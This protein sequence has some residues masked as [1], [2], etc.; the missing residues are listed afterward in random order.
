MATACLI[1]VTTSQ[2]KHSPLHSCYQNLNLFYGSSSTYDF[3]RRVARTRAHTR[4]CL[5]GATIARSAPAWHDT[6]AATI[7][8]PATQHGDACCL[9]RARPTAAW[10]RRIAAALAP[11]TFHGITASR[12]TPRDVY[13]IRS[14]TVCDANVFSTRGVRC[15][16]E[17]RQTFSE[18]RTPRDTAY[19]ASGD[20]KHTVC[21]PANRWMLLVNRVAKLST[22]GRWALV[23]PLAARATSAYHR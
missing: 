5:F 11:Q 14:L 7:H 8:M 16:S 19:A 4:T 3:S 20:L 22:A 12:R 17:R 6:R 15:L 1:Y 9:P 10:R 13:T 21:V 2:Q 23:Q 18:R